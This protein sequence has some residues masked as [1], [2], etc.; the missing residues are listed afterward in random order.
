MRPSPEHKDLV[1]VDLDGCLV[2][3]EQSV[4]GLHL[5]AHHLQLSICPLLIPVFH[6]LSIIELLH[7]FAN[8]RRLGIVLSQSPQSEYYVF[9]EGHHGAWTHSKV[10]WDEVLASIGWWVVYLTVLQTFLVLPY[11]SPYHQQI[12]GLLPT[13][14]QGHH[15]WTTANLHRTRSPSFLTVIPNDFIT[16]PVG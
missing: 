9:V 1:R 6:V 8:W 10:H 15:G 5:A 4:F 7:H 13:F 16:F 3:I 14:Y 12:M 2:G 11:P